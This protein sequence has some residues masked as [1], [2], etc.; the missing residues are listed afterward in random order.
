MVA[1]VTPVP[2]EPGQSWWSRQAASRERT[3]SVNTNVED[4]HAGSPLSTVN[5]PEPVNR[6]PLWS[7]SEA[8]S[9]Q[10]PAFASFG[11]RV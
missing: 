1:P 11:G 6:V 3:A 5:K 2:R 9:S 10:L 8:A 4:T 7:V